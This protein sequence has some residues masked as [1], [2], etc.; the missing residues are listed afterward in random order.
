MTII[1]IMLL[2]V[3]DEPQDER[4][5][6]HDCRRMQT[7]DRVPLEFGD[8]ITHPDDACAK[9]TDSHPV[10]QTSHEAFV[11]GGHQLEN[12]TLAQSGASE[13]L[14]F[15]VSKALQV[16]L[17]TPEHNRIAQRTGSGDIVD[18]ILTRH[19]EE[20]VVEA[21]QIRFLSERQALQIIDRADGRRVDASVGKHP[22]VV[23]RVLGEVGYLLT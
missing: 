14:V 13:R 17:R 10:S 21:L 8:T 18:D 3:L 11:D 19:T 1:N 2:G 12:V 7:L 4:R 5:H 15:V 20:V 6:A 9:A 16:F 23:G 22:P